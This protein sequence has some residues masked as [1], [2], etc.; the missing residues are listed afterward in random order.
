[1]QAG[2][3]LA[4]RQFAVV[5]RKSFGLADTS[6]AVWKK[7]VS[8]DKVASRPPI[9]AKRQLKTRKNSIFFIARSLP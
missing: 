6:Q 2:W 7:P 5:A 9:S 3:Q 4:A 1:M 8:G